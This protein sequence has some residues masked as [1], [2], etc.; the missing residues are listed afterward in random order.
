MEGVEK[1]FTSPLIRAVQTAE[2][3]AEGLSFEN[4]F[5]VV[6]ELVNESSVASVQNM[7]EKNRKLKSVILVGH[8]P[9]MS[10]LVKSF[11]HKTDFKE[12]GKSSVCLI[13]FNID[14]GKSE[15][16]WYFN[17]NSMEFEN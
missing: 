1:I 4:D 16:I 5:E 15:F 6:D 3:V 7:L 11:T 8:E 12:F 14:T 2:I 10:L 9:K 13:D 17:S